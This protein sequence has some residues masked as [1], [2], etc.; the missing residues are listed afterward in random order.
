MLYLVY[1]S[2]F[3]PNLLMKCQSYSKCALNIYCLLDVRQYYSIEVEKNVLWILLQIMTC[4]AVRNF[5]LSTHLGQT[6]F[7]F[8]GVLRFSRGFGLEDLQG[9]SQT[10]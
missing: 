9:S 8:L 7:P 3:I 4:Q 6:I 2:L 5:A 1:H 10:S